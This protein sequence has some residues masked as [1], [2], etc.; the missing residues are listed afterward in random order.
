[1]PSSTAVD[2]LLARNLLLGVELEEGTD[3]IA[4]HGASSLLLKFP[5]PPKRNVGVTHVTERPFSCGRVYTR[6]VD[7]QSGP[8]GPPG[9]PRPYGA[10]RGVRS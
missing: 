8:S 6:S 5:W 7:A 1:M 2:Q 3:E 4:T 9:R 10:P